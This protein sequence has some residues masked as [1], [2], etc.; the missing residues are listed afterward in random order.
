MAVNKVMLYPKR[1]FVIAPSNDTKIFLLLIEIRYVIST[2][3]PV[4]M[5]MENRIVKEWQRWKKFDANVSKRDKLASLE[6]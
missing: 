2:F 5:E 3:P 4:L 1:I 6:L